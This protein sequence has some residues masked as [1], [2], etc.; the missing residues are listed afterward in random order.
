MIKVEK[1]KS[2]AS[3]KAI[4]VG[5]IM[6]GGTFGEYEVIK[7]KKRFY[8]AKTSSGMTICYVLRGKVNH[9]S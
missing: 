4:V 7:K 9:K 5:S 1:K 8:T 6:P 2:F 3:R